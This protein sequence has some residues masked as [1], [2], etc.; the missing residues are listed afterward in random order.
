[1][2][3]NERSSLGCGCL[4]QPDTGL[5]QLGKIVVREMNHVGIAVDMAHAGDRTTLD[6]LD[7]SREPVIVSHGNVRA[8]CDTRET[9][10]TM[11]SGPSRNAAGSSASRRTDRCARRSRGCGRPSATWSTTSPTWRTLP[12]SITSGLDRI[13]SS[14][15]RRY[16]STPSSGCDI[17]K[18]SATT[19]ST[20]C[21]STNSTEWTI[22]RY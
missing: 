2:T 18:C 11:H 13:S 21:T 1:M 6:A 20:T 7:C 12:A 16:A 17:R 10:A 8:L 22:F 3:Y 9:T 19:G 5:T 15:N 4:E 14:R